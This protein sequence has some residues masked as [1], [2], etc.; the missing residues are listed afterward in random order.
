[1]ETGE[2]LSAA[3]HDAPVAAHTQWHQGGNAYGAN[4]PEY[5]ANTWFLCSECAFHTGIGFSADE[6]GTPPS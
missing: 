5:L 6:K 2:C 1:M 4:V 3:K